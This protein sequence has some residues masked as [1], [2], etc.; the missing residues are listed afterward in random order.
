MRKF[1]PFALIAAVLGGGCA[2]PTEPNAPSAEALTG[3]AK[4]LQGVWAL[5]SVEDGEIEHLTGAA[6]KDAEALIKSVRLVFDGRRMIV[7]EGSED[8]PVPFAL[9]ETKSPKVLAL[10]LGAPGGVSGGRGATAA[11]PVTAY[12]PATARP[13]AP[14]ATS[15]GTSRGAYRGTAASGGAVRPSETWRWI[16]KIEGDALT[17]AFIKKNKTLVP[18]EFKP[19]AESNAPGQPV[20]PGVTVI[21]LKRTNEPLPTRV[22]GGTPFGGTARATGPATQPSETGQTTGPAPRLPGTSK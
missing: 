9:D 20:V 12:R 5:V 16:Y 13:A 15:F 6:K 18:T 1:I 10:E 2:R 14:R 21:K 7:I 11:R 17:V 22:R 8:E 3:D 4:A 19:R